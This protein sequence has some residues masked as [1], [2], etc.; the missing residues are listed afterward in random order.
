LRKSLGVGDAGPERR[1]KK[2]HLGLDVLGCQLISFFF[3]S[4]SPCRGPA[5]ILAA[6]EVPTAPVPTTP[7]FPP[8]AALLSSNNI[9][10]SPN[11]VIA[12]WLRAYSFVSFIVFLPI[13]YGRNYFTVGLIILIAV[14]SGEQT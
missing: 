6:V 1:E 14:S 9:A 11:F 8:P 5:H 12:R 2:L 10:F 3:L 7:A 4:L 13:K